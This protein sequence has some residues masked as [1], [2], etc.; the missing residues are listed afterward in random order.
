MSI[1]IGIT[2]GSGLAAGELL[3]LLQFHPYVDSIQV[4]S[5]SHTGISVHDIHSGLFN[6]DSITTQSTFTES[7][8]VLFLCSGHGQSTLWLE[9]NPQTESTLII[10]LSMDFRLSKEWVY[11][12]P[13]L[14]RANYSNRIANPGCFATAIQL[15][16]LPLA[17]HQLL[18]KEVHIHAMTGASGAGGQLKPT[19]QFIQRDNDISVYKAFTHQHNSEIVHTLTQLQ[20]D[21]I[22]LSL[23][24]VRG[25]FSRGIFASIYLESTD[26]NMDINEF[27]SQFYKNEPFVKVEQ[28]PVHL[29]HVVNSNF[30][31]IHPTLYDKKWHIT[32][33]IDNLLKGAAGQA[34]Q[35]MNICMGFD[36]TTA[37]NL[38]PSIY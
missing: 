25:P 15:G 2:G 35:N 19:T 18:T 20:K 3:R 6:L 32:V 36:Q 21:D 7:P 9:K 30:A 4:I 34:L 10:D 26:I 17:R 12:L 37:L 28:N 24:P 31:L 11:G 27:Y 33:A 22:T 8:D 13:E 38:K 23:I 29:K 16:L 5:G 14:N 1:K